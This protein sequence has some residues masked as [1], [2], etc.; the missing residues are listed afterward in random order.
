MERDGRKMLFIG[1]DV[2][3]TGCKA[4][5]YDEAGT[6]FGK[7]YREFNVIHPQPGWSE[8]DPETVWTSV[9]AVLW[10]A[11]NMAKGDGANLEDFA[12]ICT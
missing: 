12:A 11:V 3:T 9:L 10:E 4:A 2:G 8:Q 7:S 1:L 5:V 6:C